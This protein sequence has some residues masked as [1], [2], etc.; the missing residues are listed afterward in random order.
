MLMT[1]ETTE[2]K[3]C[4]RFESKYKPKSGHR[5]MTD[6]ETDVYTWM[7][8]PINAVLC[9]VCGLSNRWADSHVKTKD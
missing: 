4:L 5:M 7:A 9:K 1:K 8:H 2:T 3:T 6:Y